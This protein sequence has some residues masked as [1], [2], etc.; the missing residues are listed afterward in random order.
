[1]YN[2]IISNGIYIMVICGYYSLYYPLF[3]LYVFLK[4]MS[5]NHYINYC[6]LYPNP[7]LYRWKHLIRLTDTGHIANFLFYYHPEYLPLCHNVL[8]TIFAGYYASKILFSMEDKDD[9]Y[10]TG[11]LNKQIWFIVGEINHL[12]PYSIIFYYNTQQKYLFD[13]TNLLYSF[14][15]V[16]SWLIFIYIPWRLYTNDSV[17]SVWDTS[18][19]FKMKFAV[20][21]MIHFIIYIGNTIG[22]CVNTISNDI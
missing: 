17:Y 10:D 4:A 2:L 22:G 13:N 12:V 6:H 5:T 9:K 11:K 19:P 14:G 16:Y 1:M 18:V 8:F 15:W 20:F 7:Q 21:A 3:S